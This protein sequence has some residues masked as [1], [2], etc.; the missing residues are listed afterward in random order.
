MAKV[1][2]FPADVSVEA[3]RGTT[4]LQAALKA[5]VVL[6]SPCNGE[7]TCGKCKVKLQP[8]YL[9]CIVEEEGHRLTKAEKAEGFVLSCQAKIQDDIQ[10]E[11]VPQQ[12][13][14]TLQILSRGKSLEVELAGLIAKVYDEEKQNTQVWADDRLLGTE[15]GDTVQQNLGVVVDIGTTTL[16][17]SLI[18][19]NNGEEVETASSLNPQSLHAQDVLSRIKLAS[20]PEG[21][22]LMYSGVVKEINGLIASVA[23]KAGVNPQHIYEVIFSGN[24]CMLHLA[25]GVNPESLGKHPYIPQVRGGNHVGAAEHGLKIAPFGLIY[26]PPIVSA[27]VGADITSGIL[28]ADIKGQKGV[29]LFVD[30]GTNGEMVI[31]VDGRLAAASTAAGPAFEGMNITHG[32]RAGDGAI[33]LFEISPEGQITLETIGNAPAVGICGSGLL[34]IVGELVANGV[35]GKTGRYVAPERTDLPQNLKERMV[36]K[37]GKPVF[38]VA[39]GVWLTQKDVRQVQLAKGAVRAG[40]EFLLK[41]SEISAEQVDR[42]LIAGSF[43]YH[44][45]AKSLLNIGMLPQEFADRIEFVGNT[46]KTGGEA[47]LL[48][49]DCREKISQIVED[50]EVLDL[51]AY[52]NFD[53]V[54]VECL[55]F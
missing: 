48:N 52:E 35:I 1:H 16:V 55:G 21:L 23:K 37:E 12:K 51:A 20:E 36:K 14:H 2:F 46:S 39:P 42:I 6:E 33:E 53:K 29:T 50:I 28:A 49:T 38:L 5:G 7:G 34:D 45:R 26:L 3:E 13:N 11:V 24:T 22:E 47:L 44:L 25:T 17:A 9:A 40:I 54:F 19:I 10:V 41:A 18:N 8:Q 43:G 31:G 15:K 32:M 4:I 27:Y 30:I